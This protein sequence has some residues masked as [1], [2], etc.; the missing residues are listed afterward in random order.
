MLFLLISASPA[1]SPL[2]PPP[3]SLPSSST[4]TSTTDTAVAQKQ[5]RAADGKKSTVYTSSHP[6]I[7]DSS[8]PNRFKAVLIDSC[9]I[10]LQIL[11]Y[12]GSKALFLTSLTY[13]NSD[14]SLL[15]PPYL[16]TLPSLPHA[17]HARRHLTLKSK[18]LTKSSSFIST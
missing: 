17:G 15:S 14:A 10:I 13:C 1:D 6:W 5:R 11:L 18:V 2:P 16:H 4:I 8:L 3:P 7:L 12:R 9:H